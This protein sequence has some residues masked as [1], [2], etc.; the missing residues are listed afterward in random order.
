MRWV[1]SLLIREGKVTRGYLGIGGQQVPLPVRV[2]R[3]FQLSH[4]SGVRVMDVAPHSP[5]QAA[6]LR[7]GDIIVSLDQA[8][9]AGVDDIHRR[10][11]SDVI[12]RKLEV[13]LLRG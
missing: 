1:A 5:A 3:H 10:L 2:V 11:S 8:P 9:M 12:G 4:D 7:E 13:V 6:G